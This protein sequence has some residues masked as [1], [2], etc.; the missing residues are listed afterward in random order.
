MITNFGLPKSDKLYF[1]SAIID[2]NN[3]SFLGK[4]AEIKIHKIFD[5]SENDPR[6]KGFQ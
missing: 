4:D 3:N 2:L 5:N 6:I 1:S